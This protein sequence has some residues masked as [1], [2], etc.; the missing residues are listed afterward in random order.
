M[1]SRESNLDAEAGG[2]AGY[3]WRSWWLYLRILIVQALVHNDK[4]KV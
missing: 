1:L 3:K 4:R 2:Q